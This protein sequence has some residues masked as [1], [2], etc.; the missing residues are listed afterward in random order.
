M[1][2]LLI[3]CL[4]LGSAAAQNCSPSASLD[5]FSSGTY[6][7]PLQPFTSR[8][9]CYNVTLDSYY[10]NAKP[11]VAVGVSAVFNFQSD[12]LGLGFSLRHLLSA[13]N[14]QLSLVVIVN[15]GSWGTVSV[16]YLVSA[17]PEFVLGS[18][19]SNGNL[20]ASCT[21]LQTYSL[22]FNLPASL[23]LPNSQSLGIL[24]LLSGLSTT[25]SLFSLQFTQPSLDF[26]LKQINTSIITNATKEVQII[27]IYYVIVDLAK[28]SSNGFTYSF[29]LTP[30]PSDFSLSGLVSINTQSLQHAYFGINRTARLSCVGFN[31]PTCLSADSC[32]TAGG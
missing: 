17:R 25:S 27:E 22:S 29:S 4:L 13:S 6:T 18:A 3:V 28:L 10:A 19:L 8:L 32:A 24:I 30:T 7:F 20:L 16:S 26:N 9:Q 23:V 5:Q 31:C 2:S 21:K 11:Q 12:S 15:N 1:I 14:T